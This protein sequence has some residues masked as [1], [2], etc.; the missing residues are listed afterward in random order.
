M[1]SQ[2][3]QASKNL[4]HD[5][6][7]FAFISFNMILKFLFQSKHFV[8]LSACESVYFRSWPLETVD[9]CLKSGFTTH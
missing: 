2:F 7:S 8:F 3:I 1:W 9:L 5:T 4:G 6:P